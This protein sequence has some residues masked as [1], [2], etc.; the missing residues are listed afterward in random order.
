[1]LSRYSCDISLFISGDATASVSQE[2]TPFNKMSA[3]VDGKSYSITYDVRKGYLYALVT[4]EAGTHDLVNAYWNE[5]AEECAQ[6]KA[7]KLLVEERL[8]RRI[9]SLSD[10][11]NLSADVSTITGLAGVKVAFVDSDPAHHEL[12]LFGELVASNRGLYCKTFKDFGEGE[13][14]LLSN[15]SNPD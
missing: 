12:N 3:P 8:S 5:V 4:G 14:W 6:Q 11:Y 10:A 13:K 2:I 15:E 1:L 9:D 7:T